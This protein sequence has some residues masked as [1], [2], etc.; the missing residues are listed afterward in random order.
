MHDQAWKKSNPIILLSTVC[1]ATHRPKNHD[2]FILL[3][4]IINL[5]FLTAGKHAEAQ[6]IEIG[7]R[8]N[9]LSA[10][11]S[12]LSSARRK[13]E[14]DSEQLRSELEEALMEARSADER[15]KKATIDVGR[16]GYTVIALNNFN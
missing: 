14:T 8:V 7:D 5:Y 15:A 9:S 11:N 2:L 13:L 12:A 16:F 10:Q 6:L 3:F 4:L 1:K